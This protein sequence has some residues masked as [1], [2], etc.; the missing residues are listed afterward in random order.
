VHTIHGFPFHDFMSK[1]RRRLYVALERLAGR[2]TH[3]FIAVA[4]AVAREAVE[5]RLAPP[6]RIFAVPS[7]I[8]LQ[9]LVADATV[10][11]SLGVPLDVP[12]VATVG[13]L[14]FQKAPLD[15]VRM[16]ATVAAARPET[17]FVMVGQGGLLEAAQAEA[18]SLGV[19]VVFAGFRADAARIAACCDVYVVASLY[20]GL[21]R[22]LCEALAAGRPA[23]ATAVNGVVD[24]IEPG[25]TGL[26][27]PP[28]DPTA[29]AQNVI[30]LLDHPDEAR[31]MGEVARRRVRALFEPALMCRHI[32]DIY[33]HFLGLQPPAQERARVP[34]VAGRTPGSAE[35]PVRSR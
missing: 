16:A 28:A 1:R 24:I 33:S 2:M 32:E 17:R 21:G 5:M 13:R 11:A 20:E 3:A 14:D 30:W 19:G 23:A 35:E 25:V 18:R 9:D 27:S 6:G 26:L 15:F 10:R 29:L 31:E 22:A 34:G 7:A 8:E 12:L 4:P